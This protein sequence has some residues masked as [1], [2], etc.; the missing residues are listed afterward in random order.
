VQDEVL[1]FELVVSDW[2]FSSVA[3]AVSV[4]VQASQP[5]STNIAPL[6]NVV[7]SSENT[8]TDQLAV[9]V[10]D[11]GIDGYPGIWRKN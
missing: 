7:A 6:A 10:V 11:E 8:S 2:E 3:D 1:T 4:T 5:S 9:K